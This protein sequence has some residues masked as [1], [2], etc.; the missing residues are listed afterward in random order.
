M[1]LGL[2]VVL[3]VAC[4]CRPRA[5]TVPALTNGFL[6]RIIHRCRRTWMVIVF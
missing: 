5:G 1:A 2:T 4:S 6:L 3:K